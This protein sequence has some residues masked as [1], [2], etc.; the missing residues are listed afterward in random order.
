MKPEYSYK[1]TEKVRKY[2]EK[3][4]MFG[5]GDFA[6]IG[7]SGGADSVCLFL[8]LNK[9]SEA[10]GFSLMAV[11]VNHGIRGESGDEDE[12]FSRKLCEKYNVPFV[13]YNVN[14]PEIASQN[15][16]TLEEAGR[17]IRYKCLATY[18]NNI[19]N[20]ISMQ[21]LDDV[22]IS[23]VKIAVA[24]HKNDQAE[25]VLFNIIRGSGLTGIGGIKPVSKKIVDIGD[26]EE[27]KVE[28]SIIRPL[29]C[30]TREEIIAYLDYVHQDYRV[31]ETNLENEY[32]RNSIR[33][34]IIPILNKI[35]S[36]SSEHISSA[37]ED[38]REANDYIYSVV[39]GLFNEHVVANE[40]KTEY[41]IAVKPLKTE[42]PY[43]VRQLIIY[44]LQELIETY[45]DITKT[46]ICD[47]Y[48]LFNK[49]KG[50]H[51]ILPYDLVAYR[52]K[53]YIRIS[54]NEHL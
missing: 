17:N 44:V 22:D 47:I 1:L 38:I 16:L 21:S 9:L 41:R 37:A 18:A 27:K 36:R 25:T 4:N 45:K 15:G 3:N 46:H 35:Q 23:N 42:N 26:I 7:L 20:D 48:S 43:I 10:I 53:E 52:E 49:G 24:H 14:V 50:K 5:H 32:S 28:I 39:K 8:L 33:N 11:H 12:R 29:L 30:L 54:R 2:I 40:D 6:V 34:E 51:I 13:S 31:D 19:A